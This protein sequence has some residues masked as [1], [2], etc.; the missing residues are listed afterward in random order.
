[1]KVDSKYR[2]V[3]FVGSWDQDRLELVQGERG[4]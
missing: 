3:P 2:V 1:M 4:A